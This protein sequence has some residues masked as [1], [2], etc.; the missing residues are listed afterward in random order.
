MKV[1]MTKRGGWLFALL[2]CGATL[3]AA[4]AQPSYPDRPIRIVIGSG[5]AGSPTSPCGSLGKG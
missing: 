3:A 4:Q 2:L 1:A 5:R